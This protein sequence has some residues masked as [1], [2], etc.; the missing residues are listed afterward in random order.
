MNFAQCQGVRIFQHLIQNGTGNHLEYDKKKSWRWATLLR[1]LSDAVP[2]SF[3]YFLQPDCLLISQSAISHVYF[4]LS[5][6]IYSIKICF[7][8]SMDI[9]V[10]NCFC[11]SIY[12]SI[13]P[14]VQLLLSKFNAVCKVQFITL[15]SHVFNVH[16]FARK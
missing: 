3:H 14:T 1:I 6:Y 4:Y 10:P 15:S 13:L 2:L 12:I 5:L 11:L 16:S 7:N 9:N 8:F